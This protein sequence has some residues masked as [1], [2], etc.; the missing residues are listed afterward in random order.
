MSAPKAALFD[1]DDTLAE[2]FQPPTPSM[3]EKL[4]LLMEKMPVAII[5]AAGYGRMERDFLPI[6]EK[7]PAVKNLYLLPNSSAQAYVWRG[8]W[9]EEY[10]LVLTPEERHEIR[11]AI[12]STATDADARAIILDREVQVAYAAIGL[13]ATL[14]E[15]KAWDPNQA[16]RTEL[17]KKLDTL[18]PKFEVRIGGMTTIDITKKGISKAYGVQ[19]LSE[20]LKIPTSEMLYIGDALYE[21]GNDAVVIPTGIHTRP[22]RDPAE[23]EKVIDELLGAT[24]QEN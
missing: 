10:S 7:S 18:L 11:T 2:S 23:T 20:R 16:K 14:E 4:V 19:W 6:V 3:I 8:G 12:E 1:L 15:K 21:G 5:S 9:T 24:N 22:V 17:K 13:E